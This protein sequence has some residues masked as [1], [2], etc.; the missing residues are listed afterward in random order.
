MLIKVM[1]LKYVFFSP[2]PRLLH[3]LLGL[4]LSPALNQFSGL[5]DSP[6]AKREGSEVSSRSP[7]GQRATGALSAASPGA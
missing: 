5:S 4:L 7:G 3:T 1:C 2:L 6:A